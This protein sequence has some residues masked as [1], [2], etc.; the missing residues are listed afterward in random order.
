MG[1]V[2][3]TLA[4]RAGTDNIWPD[5]ADR[6]AAT[7][8]LLERASLVDGPARREIEELV[9]EL[10]VEVARDVA[11][12]YRG[13]GIDQDD[14]EQ[15]ACLGLVKAV[16]RFEADKGRDFLSFAVP[17]IRGELRRH[18]RDRGWMVRPP[19]S[20][21]EMQASING[22]EEQLVQN[23]GRSP[24]PRE[25]AAH[26]GVD[27]DL[28]VEALGAS[29]CFVPSSLD[30]PLS[31]GEA[32]ELGQTLGTHEFGFEAAEARAALG[33]VLAT[34][35]DRE[36]LILELRFGQGRTQAEIGAEIGVTQM[37]VSRLLTATLAKLRLAM[38]SA[39]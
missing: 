32:A 21:Q 8:Q 4:T 34:L 14:L 9:V 15:V 1:F 36:R 38:E 39:A 2:L 23:L 28:V 37:Q 35:T 11:R 27:L 30:A 16:R 10:N 12:R 5:P 31:P 29:G 20:I 17:T 19:R 22:A 6:R 18:F 3:Q 24:R 25:I 7:A 13:R 33:P 26:L